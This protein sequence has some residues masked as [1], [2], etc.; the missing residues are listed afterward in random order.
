M[1]LQNV[2]GTTLASTLFLPAL[3]SAQIVNVGFGEPQAVPLSPWLTA[4]MAAMLALAAV[5]F[6]R[7]HHRSGMFMLVLSVAAGGVAIRSSD[8][9]AGA[10]IPPLNLVTSPAIFDYTGIG[11]SCNKSINVVASTNTVIKSIQVS[12][13][14]PL[15][16]K[17]NNGAK[18]TADT[19]WIIEPKST[20]KVG[21]PL[22]AS[23]QCTIDLSAPC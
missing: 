1:K 21:T 11:G 23:G 7:K 14:A 4:F 18:A 15:D 20:C 13:G 3:A 12:N 9:V 17:P 8:S 19:G 6:L 2:L 16:A 5:A 10:I 22:A